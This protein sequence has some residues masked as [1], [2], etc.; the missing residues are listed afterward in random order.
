MLYDRRIDPPPARDWTGLFRFLL[1]AGQ[2]LGRAETESE[3]Y[4]VATAVR[5]V[6]ERQES[7]FELNDIPVPP[8][9]HGLGPA[10]LDTFGEALRS[11]ATWVQQNV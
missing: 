3:P 9:D 11:I 1:D 10:Y 5:D 7:T 2:A 6:H 4:L 8:A